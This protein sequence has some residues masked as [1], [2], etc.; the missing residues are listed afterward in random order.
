MTLAGKKVLIAGG[1]GFLGTNLA[2]RLTDL[3]AHLRLT[4]HLKPLQASF[5]GAEI[6]QADLRR[7]E[8]CARA[9]EGMD[10][11]FICSAHTSG[12]AAIRATPLIH[13]TPNV[14]INTLLLEAAYQARV[15]KVCFLSSGAA[16]PGTGDRPV[17]EAEM[18]DS[19]PEEVYYPAG[20]MK[21]YAEILCRTYAEKISN[22]MPTVVVRPSNVY[23]PYDKF[24]FAVSHVTAAL[25]RR[26]VERQSPLE[27]WGTGDDI[28]DLIYVDDFVDGAIAAVATDLPFLAVNICA[29]RGYAVREMLETL[30][31]VDGFGGAQ[32]TFDR[33]KPST[34]PVRLMD[35]GLARTLLGFEAQVPLAEG[36][37]RTLAW[38]RSYKAGR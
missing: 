22:P 17:T 16:Y 33:S 5:P 10:T 36:L 31:E 9:V 26:V 35:N 2:L 29:G 38:Y 19:E 24:D 25:L 15:G 30:L 32:V 13:I 6:V 18:F 14:L 12:A 37:R 27:V 23:G 3:G 20:W 8:D 7:P 4:A 28:R 1:S 11:V 21:R 34:V